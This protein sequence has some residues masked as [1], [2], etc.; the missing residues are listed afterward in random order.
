[1]LTDA[2]HRTPSPVA[3]PSLDGTPLAIQVGGY[4][5]RPDVAD[6][7]RAART[8][9]TSDWCEFG[10]SAASA[11]AFTGVI[12]IL[13]DWNG[14]MAPAVWWL[15]AFLVIY[16]LVVASTQGP[17]V[18]TDRSMTVVI[19]L[20]AALTVAALA[21]L[22]TYVVIRGA[23]KLRLSFFREDMSTV[24]PL[25]PGGGAFHAIVGTLEQVGIATLIAVPAAILTAVYLHE[26]KGRFA[27]I[28]RFFVDAM[29]GLPSI[30]AGLL[31]Y[32][33]WIVQ[34]GKG[35]SGAAAGAALTILMLPTVT[36]TAEEILRTIPGSLREAALALGAPE[37]RVA[38]RVVLPTAR[39]GLITA[40]ILGVA[41]AIGETAPILLTA[42]YAATVNPNP[43]SGNQAS[44]PV[45]V[46][47]LV[48]QP[49]KTQIARA[50]TGALVLLVIVL[51]LF[52]VAR[53]IGS[54]GN[55]KRGA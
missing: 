11:A 1:M 10:A 14:L 50:W 43:L 4:V 6:Q 22:V 16:R 54:R 18:A 13:F 15:V 9:R 28:V 40:A 20:A 19:G 12:F 33:I 17:V 49:N 46:Y 27:P 24:G 45:F 29:S 53:V 26:I 35:F 3:P 47:Q 30:V 7:P 37:W 32:T 36:R 21:W 8:F 38:T 31:V 5:E 2:P 52:T 39:S 34:L 25:D 41:R 48:R 51:V 23:P 42:S 44:L 55:V